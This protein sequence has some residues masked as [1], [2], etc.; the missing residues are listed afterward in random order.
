MCVCAC[1]YV[2]ACACVQMQSRIA[3][4]TDTD[5]PTDLDIPWDGLVFASRLCK[6]LPHEEQV[7]KGAKAK[8]FEPLGLGLVSGHGEDKLFQ[9]RQRCHWQDVK[10]KH[11]HPFFRW[12]K[13]GE[14][15]V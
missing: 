2:S 6:L 1:V 11:R 14:G 9:V 3:L 12:T 7:F 4:F 13:R 8:V 10:Q 15:S 5:R